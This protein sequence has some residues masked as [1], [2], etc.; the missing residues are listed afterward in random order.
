MVSCAREVYEGFIEATG[1]WAEFLLQPEVP[2]RL[3]YE[4]V[5]LP[6]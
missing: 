2:V 1:M 6:C 5:S 4:Y 3:G